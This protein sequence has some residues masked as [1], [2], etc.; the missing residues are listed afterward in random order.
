MATLRAI[1]APAQMRSA[2]HRDLPTAAAL[3]FWSFSSSRLAEETYQSFDVLGGGSWHRQRWTAD[4]Y[5]ATEESES[6][7][8]LAIMPY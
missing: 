8:V 7:N 1:D 3:R 4:S 5:L 2:M 6:M